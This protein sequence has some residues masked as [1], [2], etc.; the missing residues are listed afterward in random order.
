MIRATSFGPALL[1]LTT[2]LLAPA[3]RGDL[4][5]DLSAALDTPS[6]RSADV[7]VEVV[8][9]GDKAGQDRTLFS[10]QPDK[11]LIP[12]SNL[13]LVTS[14]AAM[15]AL[16]A[17]FKFRTVLAAR[18]GTLAL[19]GDGDPTLG[20]ADL[21]SGSGWGVRT[22]FE[23]WAD[24][25]K[26]RGIT[27]A[28]G[29]VV[30]DSVFDSVFL[31]PN[32][33]VNQASKSYVPQVAGVNLNANLMDFFLS[34][35]GPGEVVSYKTLPPTEYATVANSCVYGDRNAVVL[36]RTLGTN[37]IVLGGETD[38]RE[39]GPL[40]VTV[41][42]PPLFAGTVLAETLRGRGIDLPAEVRRDRT[43]RESL[44]S[45]KGGWRVVAVLETPLSTVLTQMNKESI[46]LYAEALCKRMGAEA[47]G[48]P[49]SWANGTAAMGAYLKKVGVPAAE[50]SFDGG[51]G[52]SRENRVSASAM[53]AVLAKAYHGQHAAMLFGSLSVAG[54]D[55]TLR[56][57]FAAPQMQ[58]LRGRVFGKS[59]YINNVSTLSGYLH[60]R[61][62]R[63]YAF[64][65]LINGVTDVGRAKWA[66]ESVV[67]AVDD[68]S[69]K[70]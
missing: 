50:F 24:A 44:K 61:D 43:V 18:G 20:D 31:H 9:L 37:R 15:D 48:K 10:R 6:L 32:W 27:S 36:G 45:G 52:L 22:I 67:R 33:P 70:K 23:K 41:D 19:V 17:D 8:A 69:G 51:S 16:G 42:D 14:A 3:A 7:G 1:L 63:W 46:N 57:R 5:A 34:A 21:L 66:Q 11:P 62:G 64:T 60:G 13:K 56:N 35:N 59:G 53:A 40:Q 38:A 2:L 47:T 12:A 28:D 26:A 54:T 58:D 68:W 65:V 30:D 39:T 4:P 29:L 25:L 49:G 55:G